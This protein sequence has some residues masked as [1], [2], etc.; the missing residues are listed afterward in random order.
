MAVP[1][2]ISEN[3][4]AL[5]RHLAAEAGAGAAGRTRCPPRPGCKRQQRRAA[6][7]LLFALREEALKS[8]M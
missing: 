6:R 1:P 3:L 4:N 2:P 8:L 7:G 5:N